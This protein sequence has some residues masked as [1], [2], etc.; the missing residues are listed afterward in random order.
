MIKVHN[1]TKSYEDQTVL[2]DISFEAGAGEMIAFIGESGSGKSTLLKCL[3]LK[4]KWDKGTLAYNGQNVRTFNP[5]SRFRFRK[6][7]AY[8]PPSSSLDLNQTAIKNVL[9]ANFYQTSLWRKIIGK[10]SE[11]EYLYAMDYLEKLGLLDLAFRKVNTMSGGEKQRVTIAKAIVH[12]AKVIVADD[13]VAGLDP[14][15]A[16]AIL[17]DFRLLCDSKHITVLFTVPQID[18]VQKYAT[19]IIGIAGG[20]LQYDISGRRLT[21]VEKQQI[22]L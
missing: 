6:D 2:R 10:A 9:K 13:P 20:S 1:L 16:E 21:S 12:G 19:R 3:A 22:G 17:K 14:H 4:E 5:V 11:D 15:S 8:L 7:W 18:W